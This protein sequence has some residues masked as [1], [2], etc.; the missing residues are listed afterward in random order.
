L[1]QINE[2]SLSINQISKTLGINWR[3]AKK[4]ADE[5]QLPVEKKQKK[6]GMMYEEKWGEIVLDWLWEDQ[7]LKKKNRRTN[8]GIF[9]AL[10]KLGF[11]GSYGTVSYFI[12]DWRNGR[13]DIKEETKD[14][15]Y[16]RLTHPR[17]KHS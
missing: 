17:Q 10:Q 6:S 15:N 13:E 16:E 14:R 12:A 9:L 3:T 2:K 4:Y 8:K 11:K 1:Y 7:K 5:D